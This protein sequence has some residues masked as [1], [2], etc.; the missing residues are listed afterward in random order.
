MKK[1][2][3]TIRAVILYGCMVLISCASIP[4]PEKS[5]PITSLY[6]KTWLLNRVVLNGKATAFNRSELSS[7]DMEDAFSLQIASVDQT[8]DQTSGTGALRIS[9]KGAPNR[10]TAF[11]EAEGQNGLRIREP[12][13]TLMAALNAPKDLSERDYFSYLAGAQTWDVVGGNLLIASLTKDGEK[14]KLSYI[15]QK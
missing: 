2:L 3:K 14:V 11:A 12:A 1:V 4:A 9:G 10:Y 15:E 13:A 8:S 7:L 5:A 6:G